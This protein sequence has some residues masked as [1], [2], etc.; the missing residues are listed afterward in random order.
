MYLLLKICFRVR[1][2]LGGVMGGGGSWDL[3]V[4]L[5]YQPSTFGKTLWRNG[6]L[7]R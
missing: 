6:L 1:W 4:L 3:Q 7:F 5:D 2:A